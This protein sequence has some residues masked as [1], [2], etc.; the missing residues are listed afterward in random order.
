M[1]ESSSKRMKGSKVGKG[2]YRRSTGSMRALR[3]AMTAGRALRVAPAAAVQMASVQRAETALA[4]KNAGYVD[5]NWTNVAF[6]NANGSAVVQQIGIVSMGAAIT[7]RVG[8]KIKWKSVQ[9]R[10]K[11]FPNSTASQPALG[12]LLIVY[13]RYP[14]GDAVPTPS[15]ILASASSLALLQDSN[16]TRFV[17]VRRLDFVCGP[18]TGAAG[19][20]SVAD[21]IHFVDEYIKLRGL[22]ATYIGSDAGVGSGGMGDIRTGALYALPIG[23]TDGANGHVTATLNMRVR[24]ADIQG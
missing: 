21:S 18:A 16:R 24:F 10:G 4:M 5:T 20:P 19:E 7:Q 8:A 23:D 11:I 2:E 17:I 1:S 6:L 12:S 22:S 14:K 3:N 13:D 15:Q 9:I